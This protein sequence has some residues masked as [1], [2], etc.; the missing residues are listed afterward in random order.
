MADLIQN[1]INNKTVDCKTIKEYADE[2]RNASLTN[3]VYTPQNQYGSTHPNALQLGGAADDPLNYK[4]KG[5]GKQF[6]FSNGGGYYDIYGH[7]SVPNSGR[8]NLLNQNKY[9]PDNTY[10][11]CYD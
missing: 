6:D 9:R 4:G 11:P 7:P 10:K 5:T 8:L 2:R 1:P 3:N